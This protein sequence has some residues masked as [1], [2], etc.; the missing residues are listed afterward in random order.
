M[1]KCSKCGTEK[2]DYEFAK[3]KAQCKMCRALIDKKFRENNKLEVKIYNSEYRKN[4]K[5]EIKEKRENKKEEMKKYQKLYYEENREVL[6]K[7]NIEYRKENRDEII[8]RNADYRKN[9]VVKIKEQNSN[10]ENKKKRNVYEKKRKQNDPAFKL[11]KDLSRSINQILK[12][13]GSSKNGNSIVKFLPYTIGE[14]KK[15]IEKQFE[16]WMN[17]QNQGKY[18][19]ESWDDNDQK[20]WTWQLDHIIPQSTF[21]YISMEDQSFKDCWALSNLRP[22]SAKQNMLDGTSK[23]RHI[24]AYL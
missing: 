19:T 13:K 5:E 2:E 1:K 23:N 6:L 8:K 11:R 24:T 12:R 17:W 3:H 16:P 10:P 15:H 20:T 21:Q 14:L 9:N 7:Y 22:L 18:N 4:N